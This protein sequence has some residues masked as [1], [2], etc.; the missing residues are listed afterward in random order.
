MS[1]TGKY[2]SLQYLRIKII[3][4]SGSLI[5]LHKKKIRRG[6]QQYPGGIKQYIMI[7]ASVVILA[8]V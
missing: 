4:Y 7:A 1:S 5:E 8:E 6:F 3:E 2:F